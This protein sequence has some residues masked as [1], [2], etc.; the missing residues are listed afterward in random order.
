MR[1]LLFSLAAVLPL[2]LPARGEA[3]ELRC[4]QE[5]ASE[6]F[7]TAEVLMRCGE[8]MLKELRSTPVTT[9]TYVQ[10]G[11]RRVPVT[12]RTNVVTPTIEEWTYNFGPRQLMQIA[13][14]ENGRLVDVR[15]AGY[16]R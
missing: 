3:A 9:T 2:L 10:Q 14:F 13:V 8:P 5:L 6:G 12:R 1:A 7:S 15:T 4:G 11:N 16:G